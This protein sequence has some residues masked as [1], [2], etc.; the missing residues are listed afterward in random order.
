[1]RTAGIAFDLDMKEDL[2]INVDKE[3]LLKGL[4]HLFLN[5]RD[6]MP[7]GGSFA[8]AAQ[9]THPPG[10]E[11][12]VTDSGK[13]I[14]VI[15]TELIFEPFFT[16]GKNNAAGL[17]LSIAKRIVELHGGSIHAVNRDG[18]PGAQFIITLPSL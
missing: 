1:C 13:G 9:A 8:V 3:L 15:P 7:E 14:D 18:A 16:I 4:E 12:T 10:A 6:A 17:G 5:S 2:I 11:I